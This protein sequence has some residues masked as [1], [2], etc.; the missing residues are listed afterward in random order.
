L[1]KTTFAELGISS[2]VCVALAKNGI[3]EPF[4]VQALVIG[5][6]IDGSDLLVRS[7]TGSGKTLAF[8]LPVIE[9]LRALPRA[10]VPRALVLAP[11]P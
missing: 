2:A 4:D 1:T 10:R 7:P 5:E 8:G 6:A 9:R 3:H 11:D